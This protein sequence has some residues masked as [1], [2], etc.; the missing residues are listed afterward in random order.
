MKLGRLRSSPL[1]ILFFSQCL[2]GCRTGGWRGDPSLGDGAAD[3]ILADAGESEEDIYGEEMEDTAIEDPL[4]GVNRAMF[5]F[6][7]FLLRN[8]TGPLVDF[9]KAVTNRF[10]RDMVSN[11]GNRLNDP[12]V[13]LS[14]LLQFDV[15]NVGNTLAVFAVNMTLGCFGLFDPAG[16]LFD[17]HRENR[18]IGQVLALYGFDEGFYVVL[19]FFGPSNLRDGIGLATAFYVDPLASNGLSLGGRRGSW[20]PNYLLGPKYFVQYIDMM[21]GAVTLDTIFIQS[22]LDPYVFARYGYASNLRHSSARLKRGGT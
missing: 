3:W 2:F 10:F 18:T 22:S 20:T 16:S 11:L 12:V 1:V 17:L 15:E 14:S 9:Y 8:V 7:S 19:P 21:D 5:S 6:N 4:E 13:L